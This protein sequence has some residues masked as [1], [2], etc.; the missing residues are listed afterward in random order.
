MI[1]KIFVSQCCKSFYNCTVTVARCHLCRLDKLKLVSH[2]PPFKKVV[3]II[4]G[5]ERSSAG[6]SLQQE[7]EEKPVVGFCP[8]LLFCN[9]RVDQKRLLL[10][11]TIKCDRWKQGWR[12]E[13][14]ETGSSSNLSSGIG[15][16]SQLD[17][18]S[19]LRRSLPISVLIV[20]ITT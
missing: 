11:P 16:I 1:K 7:V 12:F 5:Q 8:A 19:S 9:K 20:E 2:L 3:M 15:S 14:G 4:T 18:Q 6:W 10:I 13:N 17:Y